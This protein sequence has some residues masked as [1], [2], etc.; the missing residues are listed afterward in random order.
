MSEENEHKKLLKRF[1]GPEKKNDFFFTTE[2][3]PIQ[4]IIL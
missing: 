4:N 3:R 1:L 2:A